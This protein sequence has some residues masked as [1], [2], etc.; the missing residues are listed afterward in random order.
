MT[1]KEFTKHY[2]NILNFPSLGKYPEER[3][4]LHDEIQR[5]ADIDKIS[6]PLYLNKICWEFDRKY[7]ETDPA[8]NNS[9]KIE[10]A[11]TNLFFL[12]SMEGLDI[13]FYEYHGNSKY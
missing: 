2:N 3:Y 5:L 9:K 7:L 13:Q 11:S 8:D 10:T 6:Y 4:D 12:R 1:K